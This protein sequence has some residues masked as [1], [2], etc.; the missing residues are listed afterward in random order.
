MSFLVRTF[1]NIRRIVSTG[2][3][4]VERVTR[5]DPIEEQFSKWVTEAK[6]YDVRSAITN[7]S[8]VMENPH[9]T[10]IVTDMTVVYLDEPTEDRHPKS[11]A[12]QDQ[13][14]DTDEAPPVVVDDVGGPEGVAVTAPPDD[15]GGLMDELLDTQ[16]EVQQ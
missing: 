7:R 6:P 16:R 2:N 5:G 15:D 14:E 12:E 4:V 9:T 8:S 3:G 11:A 1:T 13:T 10:L